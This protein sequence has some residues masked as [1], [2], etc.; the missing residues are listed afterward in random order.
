MKVE[1]RE[2]VINLYMTIRKEPVYTIPRD[3]LYETLELEGHIISD[4]IHQL[5]GKTWIKHSALYEVAKVIKGDFPESNIDWAF[6][7][8]I[9]EKKYYLEHVKRVKKEIE[10]NSEEKTN[11]NSLTESIKIGIEEQNEEVNAEI[12]KIVETQM[13]KYNLK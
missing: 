3:Q 4:W 9:V 5:L 2:D 12:S 6:T 13:E 7:F 1:V 11:Y 8:F 10:S